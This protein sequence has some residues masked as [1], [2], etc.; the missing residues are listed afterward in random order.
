MQRNTGTVCLHFPHVSGICIEKIKD[1]ATVLTKRTLND[2]V[3]FEKLNLSLDVCYS[4]IH[5][6]YVD[7][8][9]MPYLLMYPRVKTGGLYWEIE[10]PICC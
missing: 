4:L 6:R 10:G 2:M 1:I 8:P 3:L 9:C 5:L 7:L